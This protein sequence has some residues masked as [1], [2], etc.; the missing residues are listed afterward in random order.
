MTENPWGRV[1]ASGTVFVRDGSTEREVG[2]YPDVP[3]NEALA[4]FVRKFDDMAVAVNLL[5]RRVATGP[6][7]TDI[8]K[9]LVSIKATIE[10][11]IGVG[12][13]ESLRSRVAALETKLDGAKVEAD[14]HR[15]EAKAEALAERVSLVEQIEKI[16]QSN[17]S[18]VNWKATTAAVDALFENWQT[19]QRSGVKVSKE[20]ADELWKRFRNARAVIDR[21]RRAHFATVD[22]A[23]KEVKQ[24]KEAL[25]SQAEALAE[26]SQDRSLDKYRDLLEQWKKSGRAS[27]KVDDALWN[28]FKAAGDAIYAKKKE[29]DDAEDASFADNLVVKEAIIADGQVLLTM[30]NREEARGLLTGLQK[31][32]DA[33]GKVPRAKVKET[34]GAMRKLELAVKKLEDEAWSASDPEKQARQEGLA[35][36]IHL[37]IEKLQAELVTAKASGDKKKIEQIE[38]AVATQKSWLDVLP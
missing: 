7:V 38:Q 1:D 8:S 10:L 37:K 12:D 15:E 24:R 23:T 26:G 21:A 17:L 6:S 35:G 31:R 3:A 5:E 16:S 32:W 11:G 4:Y 28:R 25:I 2:A 20:Q 36:A 18:N 30:T 14:A 9:G 27:K 33:A 19:T 22:S 34:E 29:I 13:F